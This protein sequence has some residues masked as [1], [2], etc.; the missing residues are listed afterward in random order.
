MGVLKV[1]HR[2]A[3]ILLGAVVPISCGANPYTGLSTSEVERFATS[4]EKLSSTDESRV[5]CLS[6]MTAPRSSCRHTGWQTQIATFRSQ[7]T[8]SSTSARS[9]RHS[10]W[11][12]CT[13]RRPGKARIHRYHPHT[14]LPD[15]RTSVGSHGDHPSPVAH[16][17]GLPR[18]YSDQM[19]R[20]GTHGVASRPRTL[21]RQGS[22]SLH[23]R[24]ELAVQPRRPDRVWCDD[25][26]GFR[27]E[28]CRL[29]VR[30]HIY[31]PAG[32]S[33]AESYETDQRVPNRAIGYPGPF[34]DTDVRNRSGWRLRPCFS[35]RP[36]A[37]I[38]FIVRS[39]TTHPE[40]LVSTSC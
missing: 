36:P 2:L 5:Q 37:G 21:V 32:I 18:G 14:H 4:L 23:P 27:S 9:T 35:R 38:P 33:N 29:C 17:P 28:L 7:S 39:I 15:Y 24:R 22:V 30:K 19:T 16:T 11:C 3:G 8:R 26:A 13:A 40:M 25:R 34:H 20:T 6:P 10:R 31:E 1:L 12:D